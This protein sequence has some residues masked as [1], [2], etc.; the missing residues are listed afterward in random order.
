MGW[1]DDADPEFGNWTPNENM[2]KEQFTPPKAPKAKVERPMHPTEDRRMTVKEHATSK[3]EAKAK[4][5]NN[6]ARRSVAQRKKWEGSNQASERRKDIVDHAT[7][8]FNR[9][10]TE[11]PHLGLTAKAPGERIGQSAAQLHQAIG[12]TSGGHGYG[13]MQLPG[14][15]NPH[16]VP[17]PKRWEEL[18]PEEQER[19]IKALKRHAGTTMDKMSEDFGAQLDQSSVRAL[20]A[21]HVRSSTGEP[22]PF[23]KHFYGGDHPADAPEPLDNPRQ[24]MMDVAHKHETPFGTVVGA[25]ALTSPNT[26]FTTGERGARTSTNI[27]AA[28]EAIIQHGEGTAARNVKHINDP[29][30]GKAM[31]TAR[32]ANLVRAAR[33]ME[34]VDKGEPMATARNAPSKSSPEGSSMWNAPKVGPFNNSFHS[35][36]PDFF[37]ADV[38]S[39][40]GGMLPHL[41]T[42]KPFLL[43]KE[44][45]RQRIPEHRDDPRS[46]AELEAAHGAHRIYK[47]DKSERENVIQHVPNFHAMADHAARQAVGKRGLGS[48]VREPQ[49]MQW[50]EEQIERKRDAPKL[51][52]PSH[53]DAYPEVNT[54]HTNPD[55]GQLGAAAPALPGGEQRHSVT[56]H[57]TKTGEIS[58]QVR[59]LGLSEPVPASEEVP[60][61]NTRHT[62]PDQFKDLH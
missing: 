18:A 28:E 54:R 19:S 35:D 40:G 27:R 1:Q 23:T 17:T 22:V 57:R 21:G 59:S 8:E 29:E 34:H 51:D 25:T 26:K 31:S 36:V 53:A 42:E 15:E 3:R 39:G 55:Q 46:D 20:R 58:R 14:M 4:D 13:D 12:T 2:N 37:V 38:H 47:K 61:F 32:P 6:Q 41:G 11:H 24:M 56:Q 43:D 10:A 45:N 62:N 50:G 49:A 16:A 52:V 48:S 9:I 7:D 5:E 44:G 60:G 30:T 33:M